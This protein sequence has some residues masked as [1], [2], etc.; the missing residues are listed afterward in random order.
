MDKNTKLIESFFDAYEQRFSDSL[1]SENI[2]IEEQAD[3]FSECF[4]GANPNGVQCVKNDREFKANTPALYKFY[5]SIGT[6]SMKLVSKNI[7]LLNEY[8]AL[9]KTNW[10]TQITKKDNSVV[11]I[12]FDNFYLVQI[13][14]EKVK[15]FAYITDD[16]QKVLKEHGI[17]P[18]K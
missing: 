8:H 18:Y 1:G 12:V 10:V 3:A 16:E 15:I 7:T 17:A 9:V 4:I 14:N 13:L 5:Q 2:D 11:T 6:K